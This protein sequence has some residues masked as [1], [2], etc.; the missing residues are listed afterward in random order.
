MPHVRVAWCRLLPVQGADR[1]YQ[2][3]R[4]QPA[5]DSYMRK[6]ATKGL[7]KMPR[8]V[9]MSMEHVMPWGKHWVNQYMPHHWVAAVVPDLDAAPSAHCLDFDY[10]DNPEGDPNGCGFFW[11]SFQPVQELNRCIMD[12]LEQSRSWSGRK[13]I[14]GAEMAVSNA[15]LVLQAEGR[16]FV[17]SAQPAKWNEKD[18]PARRFTATRYCPDDPSDEESP[19]EVCQQ[20]GGKLQ[21][22]VEECEYINALWGGGTVSEGGNM[23]VECAEMKAG[24]DQTLQEILVGREAVAVDCRVGPDVRG[25]V[26]LHA[27]ACATP[28]AQQAHEY[29]AVAVVLTSKPPQGFPQKLPTFVSVELETRMK[30]MKDTGKLSISEY[31]PQPPEGSEVVANFSEEVRIFLAAEAAHED[32]ATWL[33][34][35][36]RSYELIKSVALAE[37]S[38][39]LEDAREAVRR[40]MRKSCTQPSKSKFD[41]IDGPT[42]HKILQCYGLQE[43]A[44]KRERN[45]GRGLPGLDLEKLRDLQLDLH[46]SE[47]S[48]QELAAAKVPSEVLVLHEA[49]RCLPVM[50]DKVQIPGLPLPQVWDAA[51][52]FPG[53]PG[54]EL[55]D[56]FQVHPVCARLSLAM[57]AHE[58]SKV[59]YPIGWSSTFDLMKKGNPQWISRHLLHYCLSPDSA[60]CTSFTVCWA[61]ILRHVTKLVHR[62]CNESARPGHTL[63]STGWPTSQ[64]VQYFADFK[65][66]GQAIA[67]IF[68]T[69]SFEIVVRSSRCTRCVHPTAPYEHEHSK[70][71]Q[72]NGTLTQHVYGSGP[73]TTMLGYD[74][75]QVGPKMVAVHQ[76]I[77]EIVEHEIPILDTA[78]FAAIVGIGPKF[79]YNSVQK[80]LLMNYHVDEFSICLNKESGKNGYLTWGTDV[81]HMEPEDVATARVFGKHHWATNLS[82]IAT[83]A[84]SSVSVCQEGCAAIIDSGTSLIAA[85]A[86]ALM[87]LGQQ[88]GHIAEDC[89]NLHELPNLRFNLDGHELEL[90]PQAYVMRVVGASV[91]A[92]SIWDLLFFKPKI[93]KIDSCMPAFMEMDMS[94]QLGPVWIL[95][96]PFFRYYHT[97]FNRERQVMRF[98]KAGEDCEPQSIR[99]REDGDNVFLASRAA[100]DAAY[101]P[102]E[103]DL[104]QVLP[105]RFALQYSD[106]QKADLDL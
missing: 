93:R 98:A 68:D 17:V 67:A 51:K 30:H 89:S 58:M 92:D 1:Q 42:E 85:P 46:E 15:L 64:D 84:N 10:K 57:I 29:G 61:L 44:P 88:I 91:E 81:V 8:A 94:T 55:V 37:L 34:T 31:Q 36:D 41:Q 25:K 86:A 106:S 35:R 77:W 5:L 100:S 103:V 4:W 26:V 96:M 53:A 69:G 27:G 101:K 45:G 75:V 19:E 9:V 18:L 70:T 32:A 50:W 59:P 43:S 47:S 83:K 20:E 87:E 82:H 39:A 2:D 12:A 40:A 56:S 65:I 21:V 105:P 90:P 24:T 6:E 63:P 102:L 22:E 71:Y 74:T 38:E 14:M 23:T 95:G 33:D 60:V 13:A 97:T 66:G 49:S 72:E 16:R 54:I 73:C 11:R 80:T 28:L 79:G 78:K 76:P 48:L 7:Q 3:V 62:F 104:K 99:A 52:G